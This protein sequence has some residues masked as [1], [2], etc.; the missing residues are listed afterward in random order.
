LLANLRQDV[1]ADAVLLISDRGLVVARAGDL[2]DSSMEVSLISA[3][4]AIF[5]ASLKVSRSMRQ[6]TLNPFTIF[7]GGD[8][9]L[10][11]MAVN[12]SYAILLASSR[13]S[14]RESLWGVLQAMQAVRNELDK[15]LRSMGAAIKR[16][17]P[18][19]K[20]SP[21]PEPADEAPEIDA[22]LKAGGV[23]SVQPEEL[24]RFW[25]Q[26]AAASS[27]GTTIPG[28]ISY[29]EARK[30]GLTPDQE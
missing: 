18:G 27:N 20:K 11:L 3:L 17:G 2:R 4:T 16:P 19:Q 10:V 30:M 22:L 1:Q 15:S 26:A 29:E 8:Q 14:S 6:E 25:E 13:L 5:S 9:D 21:A 24:D 12:A 7:T 23:K 28:A